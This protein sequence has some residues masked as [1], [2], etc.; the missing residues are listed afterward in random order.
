[1]GDAVTNN[2]PN[3]ETNRDGGESAHPFNTCLVDGMK[4]GA[5]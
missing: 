2:T 3:G 5:V 4:L 1:M